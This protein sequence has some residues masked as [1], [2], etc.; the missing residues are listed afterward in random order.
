MKNNFSA[1]GIGIGMLP[2][3]AQLLCIDE[4]KE[5]EDH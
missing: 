5:T 1:T 3:N 4:S 2:G